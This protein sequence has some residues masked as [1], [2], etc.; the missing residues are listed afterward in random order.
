MKRIIVLL[1][2]VLLFCINLIGCNSSDAEYVKNKGTLV[3][4]I[5]EYEPMHIKTDDG[6]YIGFDAEFTQLVAK[7]LGVEVEFKII[8]WDEKV[9]LLNS[10]EIDCIWNGYSINNLDKVDFS[11]PYAVNSQVFV[12][13]TKNKENY[14]KETLDSKIAIAVE[15]GS[16]AEHIINDTEAKLVTHPTQKDCILAVL[17]GETEA[18]VVDKAIFDSLVHSDLSIAFELSS[19]EF[20]IGFRRGSDLV[21]QINDLIEAMLKDGTLQRLAEKYEI[22]LVK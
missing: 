19:E 11:I 12:V 4:G 15:K 7:K 22:E 5:T 9:E 10:K 13:E 18:C 2:S 6:D 1:V 16:S 14:S 17:N 20:G 3:V 21:L 8:N